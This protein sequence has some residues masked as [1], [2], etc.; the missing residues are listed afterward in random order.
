MRLDYIFRVLRAVNSKTSIADPDNF[1]DKVKVIEKADRAKSALRRA[2][3][4]S[5]W[6][7]M[8]SKTSRKNTST[9]ITDDATSVTT[10]GEGN[11]DASD[12]ENCEGA[13]SALN[14]SE[15]PVFLEI[16]SIFD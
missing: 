10:M 2:G 1:K 9:L 6:S 15:N 5:S 7:S 16:K 4:R 8:F 13:S 11:E 14:L 12:D 3:T